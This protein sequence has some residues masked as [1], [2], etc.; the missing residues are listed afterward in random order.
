MTVDMSDIV[1]TAGLIVI[2]NTD[3]PE[4]GTPGGNILT[5]S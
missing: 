5:F 3:L 1:N 4:G 2:D